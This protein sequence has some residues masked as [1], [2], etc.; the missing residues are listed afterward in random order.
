[1]TT[2]PNDGITWELDENGVLTISGRREMKN[3]DSWY[4]HKDE[5]KRVVI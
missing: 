4:S 1:M 2:A 3:Y 5:I